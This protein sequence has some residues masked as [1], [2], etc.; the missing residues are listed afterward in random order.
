MPAEVM[1]RITGAVRRPRTGVRIA[2]PDV[3]AAVKSAAVRA[4]VFGRR[5]RTAADLVA[6]AAFRA[7]YAP[8]APAAVHGTV[9]PAVFTGRFGDR[10]F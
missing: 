9:R 4:A 8:F 2:D 6:A 3:V 5:V 1:F 10:H 7:A